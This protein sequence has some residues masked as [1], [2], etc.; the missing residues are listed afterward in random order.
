MP[1]G[2]TLHR[3]ARDHHRWFAGT[4][5]AVS[6]PQGGFAAAAAQLD[7]RAFTRAH[8]YGKHLFHHYDDAIVHI[9][10]GLFGRF[11]THEVPPPEP[12]ATVRYRVVGAGRAIDLVGATQCE[13][14]TPGDVDAI[15]SRLGPDPLRR[16]GDPEEGWQALQRR[17]VEIGR[18][19]M[20]QG[21]V[22]GVGNVFRAELLFAF[23]IH[24]LVAASDIDHDQWSAMW[25]QLRQW[26]R[27]GVRTNRIVTVDREEV[28]WSRYRLARERA[29]YVYRQEHCRRCGTPVRRWDLAGRWAYA[30]ESCQPRPAG[31]T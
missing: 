18:A 23:G 25:D 7:G 17:R 5:V 28:G 24:P 4:A 26:M 10:L 2:H 22:A 31:S 1:E 9:H 29:T 21:V 12:R 6:A 3:L 19:L 15:V 30:C 16:D 11:F 20:D 14:V 8:A 27:S 13:L